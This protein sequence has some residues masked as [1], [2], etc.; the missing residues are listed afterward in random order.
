MFKRGTCIKRLFWP[1]YE[2][3][4]ENCFSLVYAY[5]FVGTIAKVLKSGV[6]LTL[7]V[8]MITKMTAK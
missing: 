4:N 3:E 8:A 1:P 5:L 2:A 6:G 7:K